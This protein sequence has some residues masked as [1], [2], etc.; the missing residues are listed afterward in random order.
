MGQFNI[1]KRQEEKW[2][3]RLLLGCIVCAMMYGLLFAGDTLV[4]GLLPGLS[5]PE[6]EWMNWEQMQKKL[7]ED[8]FPVVVYRD[9]YGGVHSCTYA[10]N[11]IPAYFY[12]DEETESVE[13]QLALETGTSNT[14]SIQGNSAIETSV[15]I[16][17][18]GLRYSREQLS[19]FQFMIDNCY[20]VDSTTYV[21][22][23][24]MNVDTLLSMDMTM[25]QNNEDYQI[26][27]YHTHSSSET[28]ADSRPGVL[29]D[30]TIGLGDTLTELLEGY[31]YRVYHD[32]TVYDQVDGKID[33]NYAYT[34]SG[35]G[36]DRILAEHP[37]IEVVIDLHRDGVNEN[38]HLVTNINGKPT[39]KIMFFNG[40]SRTINNGELEYLANPNRQ[41]NLAFSMQMYLTGASTYDDFL[42]RTY[43]KGYQYNL[44]RRPK[45]TLIEV[46]G[47]TNTV[48][49]AQ[50]AME[51]LAYILNQVLSG[52]S[53]NLYAN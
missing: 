43:I 37:S 38:T 12:Q 10:G 50:N 31:G 20:V 11:E 44:N 15:P 6:E 28:F 49:E 1:E 9:F 32:R 25:Q 27:I 33:R 7:M 36:I 46:G 19:D 17:P 2:K 35:Q 42:R 52:E 8:V 40:V 34:L 24:E 45:A 16:S 18:T 47:Q 4:K 41:A 26:L 29:E 53:R 48:E 22:R 23:E 21:N 5:A 30:T 39:A 3:D 14:G 51:P 13:T